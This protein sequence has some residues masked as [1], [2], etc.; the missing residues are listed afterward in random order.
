MPLLFQH[1]N[2]RKRLRLSEDDEKSDEDESDVSWTGPCRVPLTMIS[3][4]SAA[5]STHVSQGTRPSCCHFSVLHLCSSVHIVLTA[6]QAA[7]CRTD[8][9]AVNMAGLDGTGRDGTGLDWTGLEGVLN[10]R[11]AL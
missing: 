1:Q 8:M 9:N 5:C 11:A 2:L 3:N 6:E 4:Q 10:G 7:L